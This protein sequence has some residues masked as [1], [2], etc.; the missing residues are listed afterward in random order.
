[1]LRGETVDTQELVRRRAVGNFLLQRGRGYLRRELS[2]LD[3]TEFLF[4]ALPLRIEGG[5]GS[6]INPVALVTR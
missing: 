6:P 5:T 3:A 4:V 1:M 2:E